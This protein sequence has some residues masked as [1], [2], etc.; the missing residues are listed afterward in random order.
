MTVILR[1]VT[2][3]GRKLHEKIIFYDGQLSGEIMR[4]QTVFTNFAF[5][6]NAVACGQ[7]YLCVTTNTDDWYLSDSNIVF[8]TA[9]KKS[10]AF[11]YKM[12]CYKCTKRATFSEKGHFSFTIKQLE[13]N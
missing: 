12:R 2:E 3:S 9:K 1:S 11:S 6:Y 10:R 8:P 5:F 7:C 4:A 13:A